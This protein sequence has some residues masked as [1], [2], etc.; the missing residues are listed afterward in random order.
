M[1]LWDRVN[2]ICEVNSTLERGPSSNALVPFADMSITM[3][4]AK[5]AFGFPLEL[6]A[7]KNR[8]LKFG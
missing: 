5:R 8:R 1:R 4:T 2:A 3:V 7:D 6:S